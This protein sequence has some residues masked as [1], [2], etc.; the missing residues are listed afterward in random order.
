MPRSGENIIWKR[1]NYDHVKE[2]T[3][4]FLSSIYQNIRSVELL[5]RVRLSNTL[6]KGDAK[7]KVPIIK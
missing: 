5:E 2:F 4:M 3:N 1:M 7:M 6:R